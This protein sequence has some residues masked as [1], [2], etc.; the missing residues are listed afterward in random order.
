MLQIHVFYLIL[1]SISY[2]DTQSLMVQ[3]SV[4]LYKFFFFFWHLS[5]F[6]I[7]QASYQADHSL[8]QHYVKVPQYQSVSLPMFSDNSILFLVL[9]FK[10]SKHTYIIGISC[11]HFR[12]SLFLPLCHLLSLETLGSQE[13]DLCQYK[14]LMS[15]KTRTEATITGMLS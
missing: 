1:I 4:L 15:S 11:H 13:C 9:I 7:L 12:I 8:V 3:S 14:K 5:F 2:L 6:Y 10:S